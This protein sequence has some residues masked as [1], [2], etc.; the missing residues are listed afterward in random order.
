MRLRLF[1]S[2]ASLVLLGSV[3]AFAAQEQSVQSSASSIRAEVKPFH[4]SP[5]LWI[6]GQPDAFIL[7]RDHRPDLHADTVKRFLSHGVQTVTVSVSPAGRAAKKEAVYRVLDTQVAGV[8]EKS[9]DSRLMVIVGTAIRNRSEPAWLKAHP[10]EVAIW[11]PDMKPGDRP[12]MASKIWQEEV[13]E[14]IR[15]L[16]DHVRHS[17]YAGKVVG[18]FFTGPPGEWTDYYDFSKPAQEGFR[19][20]LR[21]RYSDLAALRKAWHN[22]KVSWDS[23]ALPQWKSLLGGDVG[24]FFDP[25]KSRHKIDFWLYHHSVPAVAISRFARA[26]K[27]ASHGESIVGLFHGYFTD[28]EWDGDD[29][30]PWMAGQF[31][32]RHKAL[33]QIV[34]DP[35]VDF[36]LAPY[37]YQERHAGGVFDPSL[38]PN[39]ILLHGKMAVVEDDTRTHLTTP[40]PSYQASEKSGDNF[41]QTRNVQETI[42]VLKRNFA[43]VFRQTGKAACGISA[44]AIGAMSGSTIRPSSTVSR[45]WA[46]WLAGSCWAKTAVS[47]RLPSSVVIVPLATRPSTT[48]RK[49]SSPGSFAKTCIASARR[50]ISI[51][52]PTS[53]IPSFLLTST[54]STSS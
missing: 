52:T 27:E 18:Y 6:N 14:E 46:T 40:H 5:T 2:W 19:E 42:S 48:C 30:K 17:A 20:W 47:V 54:S 22:D 8:L 36:I 26:V 24:V 31:R 3:E 15:D 49:S 21:G 38:I 35:N 32:M 11:P 51:S 13:A 9:P 4:G 23:I 44:S 53:A 37:D 1:V 16:V 29:E 34:K 39:T 50:S 7:Y 43:G 41:G 33:A 25:Q 28:V 12:A 45:R 10:D